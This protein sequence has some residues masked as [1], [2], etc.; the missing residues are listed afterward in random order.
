MNSQPPLRRPGPPPL[1]ST[2]VTLSAAAMPQFWLY[3]GLA[4]ALAMIVAL[5]VALPDGAS[6]FELNN[7]APV[8]Q[9]S[10]DVAP[11]QS[12]GNDNGSTFEDRMS[13]GMAQLGGT[14][15]A[16]PISY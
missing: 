8:H 5:V 3:A 4:L 13:A 16:P 11:E 2:A 10:G 1:R 15:N 6:E 12:L 14:Y 9:F 7:Q